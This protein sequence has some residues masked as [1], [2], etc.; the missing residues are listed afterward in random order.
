MDAAIAGLRQ[1]ALVINRSESTSA[2]C[3][4]SKS[5]GRT[6]MRRPA[7]ERASVLIELAKLGGLTAILAGSP[8]AAYA[9]DADGVLLDAWDA[10]AGAR[11]LLGDRA[12]VG[13]GCG[14]DYALAERAAAAGGDY[15]GLRGPPELFARWSTAH[16][17]PALADLPLDN[18]RAAAYVAAGASFL[19]CSDYV[20]TH[21]KG[22][23]QGTVNMLYAIDL[24][25]GGG[26][27][28]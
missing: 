3:M 14:N 26:A 13:L 22:V 9:L 4:S 24:A 20:W 6:A 2:T 10:I 12:I 18:N 25:A 17:Q 11:S 5:K 1:V 7:T 19:D 23:L 8:R 21:P 15:I 28:N 16:A 27:A